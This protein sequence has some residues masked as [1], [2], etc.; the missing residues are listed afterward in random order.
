[1]F[2]YIW[3]I[4]IIIIRERI[5][6]LKKTK[7]RK[8]EE[9]QKILIMYVF[10]CK[11]E[12]NGRKEME[13]IMLIVPD[14]PPSCKQQRKKKKTWLHIKTKEIIRP[15]TIFFIKFKTPK[16]QFHTILANDE[17]I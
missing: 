12:K 4:I 13:K 10:G 17:M 3:K 5:F 2:G 6:K 14:I 8:K 9:G 7:K 16:L 1:M 15:V 11:N